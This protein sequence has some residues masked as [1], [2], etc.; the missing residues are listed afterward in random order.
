MMGNT[1]QKKERTAMMPFCL[2]AFCGTSPDEA[3]SWVTHLEVC[4]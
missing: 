3:T 4:H 1:E 2:M